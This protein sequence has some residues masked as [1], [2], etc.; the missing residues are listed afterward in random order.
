MPKTKVNNSEIIV[1]L[2]LIIQS[3]E[4][5]IQIGTLSKKIGIG[6]QTVCKMLESVIPKPTSNS[7][8]SMDHIRVLIRKF[9]GNIIPQK[10]EPQKEKKKPIPKPF[11]KEIPTSIETNRRRH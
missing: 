6:T 2:Q 7:G 9:K 3:K 8:V 5:S 10:E 1:N 11:V 4:P